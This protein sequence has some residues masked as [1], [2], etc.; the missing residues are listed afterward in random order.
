[1]DTK[2]NLHTHKY[3]DINTHKNAKTK[4]HTQRQRHT[5]TKT[6]THTHK[7]KDKNAITIKSPQVTDLRLTGINTEAAT[8]EFTSP[9]GKASG[10]KLTIFP[11]PFAPSQ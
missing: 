1:M 8:L 6:K 9:G 5:H 4:T 10:T 11:S 3:K 7:Y 2:T